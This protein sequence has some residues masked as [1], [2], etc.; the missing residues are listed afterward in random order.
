MSSNQT[1]RALRGQVD[2]RSTRGIFSR[3]YARYG[4]AR[5]PKPGSLRNIQKAARKRLSKMQGVGY[6]KPRV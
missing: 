6:G 5:A 3:G 1:M 2:S 4:V